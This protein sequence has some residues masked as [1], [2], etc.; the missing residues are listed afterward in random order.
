M[1]VISPD[2]RKI[3]FVATDSNGPRKLWVQPL[4]SETA[5]PLAGTEGATLPFWSPDS[6]SIGY[7]AH[8]MMNRVDASGGSSESVASASSGRGAT[9]GKDGTILYSPTTVGGVY[10]VPA[11]GGTPRQVTFIDKS[12]STSD[13]W[14]QFLP[15]G[16]HFLFYSEARSGFG[17]YIGSLAGGKPTL[18]IRG[19]SN[20]IYAP[21]GYLLFSQQGTL[22]AQQFDAKSLQLIGQAS[23]IATNVLVM[24][25]IWL[26]EFSVSQ[27]GILTY[28]QG[29]SE[30]GLRQLLWYDRQGKQVGQAGPPGGYFT[31]ALSPDGKQ[32]ALTEQPSGQAD[33]DV[34]IYDLAR[35]TNTRLTFDTVDVQ[36]AWSP[37]GKMIAFLSVREQNAYHLYE[38]ASDGSGDV[39][40][41]LADDA[42]EVWP[43]WTP[44]GRDLVFTRYETVAG[45]QRQSIW[46][47]PLSGGG[48]PFAVLQNPQFDIDEP[49]VSP[50]GKWLAYVSTQSGQPEVYV[51][52]FIYGSGHG[53]GLWQ[54][55]SGGGDVPKWRG[56]GK[57]LFY[58]SPDHKMMAAGISEQ[59]S[60]ISIGKA[61]PL[62]TV[63]L[64]GTPGGRTYAV[65]PRGQK[66][67][68][69]TP[70]GGTGP[71]AV[72]LVVNWPA[73]LKKQ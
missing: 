57:E 72:T 26:S 41:L 1:P 16:K 23:P 31:L 71:Q 17:T 53:S 3:A 60:G 20:A 52:P 58:I 38:K 73:L 7:F 33:V 18:L 36:P 66:F 40:T 45:A 21:P 11:S 49:S 68:A 43:V 50:D 10:R 27:T 28:A 35:G 34:W 13:R 29:S 70:L 25:T 65:G 5:Q 44:D 15:D 55:S 14:P 56:D 37:D 12:G 9:W 4:D 62:F 24:S 59:G 6:R 61:T 48:K 2:G 67:L 19:S 39:K 46:A 32:V 22:M 51:S 69:I 63:N 54:V 42:N 30:A 64:A 8:G 47:L